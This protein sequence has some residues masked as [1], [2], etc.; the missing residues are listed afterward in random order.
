MTTMQ[1]SIN[2]LKS[3]ARA[4]AQ[5]RGHDMSEWR[6]T[7]HKNAESHCLTCGRWAFVDA[8]PAPN[9]IDISGE[10]VALGCNK[11]R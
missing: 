8:K 7:S 10:A 1:A 3:D 6:N 4:S 5:W 11:L 9:S 2:R